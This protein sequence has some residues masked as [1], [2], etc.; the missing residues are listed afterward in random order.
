MIA[1]LPGDSDNFM[2]ANIELVCLLQAAEIERLIE[3]LDDYKLRWAFNNLDTRKLKQESWIGTVM[4]F[5]SKNL[6][7]N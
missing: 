2:G 5:R 1:K 6:P 4:K 7:K 3:S